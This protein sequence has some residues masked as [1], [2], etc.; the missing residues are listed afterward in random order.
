MIRHALPIVLI[1]TTWAVTSH[2]GDPDDPARIRRA[3]AY[4]DAR[5]DEWSRFAKAQRGEGADKTA[6]L[7]CHTG[8]SYAL[9]RPALRLFAGTPGPAAQEQRLVKAVSLRVEHVTELDSP[10]F[11]LMY[12]FEDRKKV[13]SRGT[14]AVLNALILARHDATTTGRSTISPATRTALDHLWATQTTEGGDAGSWDWLNFGLEPWE[15]NGS[16]AFGAALAAIAVGCTPG[17]AGEKLDEPAARGVRALHDYLRR[18]FPKESLYNRLWMLEAASIT[19]GLLTA[20]QKREVINQL[21]AVRHDDGGWSLADLGTFKRVD[22]T[23]QTRESDG[24]AT[25]LALHALLAAGTPL[26]RPE[27]VQGLA[28]LRG[29]QQEDGSWRGISVNKKRDPSTFIGKL[30]TDAATATAAQALIETTKR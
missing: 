27:V 23:P 8:L 13:E 2:A 10:R 9:G 22:G 14:E 16:R 1:L 11:E 29:H 7:S 30:M 24:H 26:D 6:C 21:R 25:G 20:D 18:R 15:G 12:D 19:D 4:L 5:Q 28:W 3:I 17:Y